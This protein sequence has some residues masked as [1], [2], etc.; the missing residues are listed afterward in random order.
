MLLCVVEVRLD[1][2]LWSLVSAFIVD[3]TMVI[4]T[5]VLVYMVPAPCLD[6]RRIEPT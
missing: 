3:I 4:I 2:A 1:V 6:I 5:M